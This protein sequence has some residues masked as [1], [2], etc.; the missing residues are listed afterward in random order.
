MIRD[1]L[2]RLWAEPPAPDPPRRVPRDW[3][4]LA[5]V[6]AGIGL[7][8][9]VRDDVGRWPAA[10]LV[11][12]GLGLT[13]LWRRTRPLAM[14]SLAYGL[15][16]VLTLTGGSET[17]LRTG[18]V[19]L[20]LVYAMTR[21]GSGRDIVLGSAVVL[22]AFA[23]SA[24]VDDVPAGDIA[25]SLVFLALPGVIGACVRLWSTAR[26]RELDRMRA[27]ERAALARELHD[28]VAHHVTAM[29]VQAQ[30]GRVLVDHD[31]VTA[32]R[33]LEEVEEEGA[34]TLE[35][36]R[37]MVKV[38]R[39]DQGVAELGA[40]GG[41]LP[42]DLRLEGPLDQLPAT[43]DGAVYRIVQESV[44]NASRHAAG[45]TVI[46]VRVAAAAGL[47]HVTV[48]NDGTRTRPGRAGY[49]LTGLR[50]RTA[51][52]GGSF[53]AG[54]APDGGWLVEARLPLRTPLNKRLRTPLKKLR[55]PLKK[56]G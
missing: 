30:A 28:T 39:D 51:L 22:S 27:D 36:M 50:E 29:V 14:V 40:L 4:L 26:G 42:I 32:R 43:V 24:V 47:V 38:L 34:R 10:V 53:E 44:T 16:I 55:T 18:M 49:G 54:P 41:R 48:G 21:W 3:V 1:E 52:L 5:A 23:L 33:S 12:A 19:I 45:A 9:A 31:P 15:G 7:E 37:G 6:L 17:G 56:S 2:R 13:T 46:R 8:L 25:G 20:I 11:T 35:A